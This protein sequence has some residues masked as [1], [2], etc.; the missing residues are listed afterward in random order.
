MNVRHAHCK[1]NTEEDILLKFKMKSLQHT[2][3]DH[4]TIHR[5]EKYTRGPQAKPSLDRQSE[6]SHQSKHECSTPCSD[7]LGG[8][9]GPRGFQGVS[10]NIGPQGVQGSQG[11][12]GIGIAGAQGPQGFQGFRGSIGIQGSQ[13]SSGMQGFQGSIGSGAQGS[14]GF[15]GFQGKVGATGSQGFQGSGTTGSQGFQGSQGTNGSQGNVG[16]QGFQGSQGNIGINGSQGNVGAQGFQGN[17]GAQGFQGGFSSTIGYVYNLNAQTIQSTTVIPAQNQA[18]TFDSTGVLSKITFDGVST[19]ILPST[20]NYSALY[21]VLGQSSVQINTLSFRLGTT[22]TNSSTISII[23]GSQSLTYG[24]NTGQ[25]LL[26]G[27]AAWSGTAGDKIELFNNTNSIVTLNNQTNPPVPIVANH[28]VAQLVNTQT[29][30]STPITVLAGSSIY[31][32]IQISNSSTL[33]TVFTVTD[34]QSHSYSK[35]NSTT[36]GSFQNIEIWYFDGVTASFSYTVTA[37]VSNAGSQ[38]GIQ[39]VEIRGASSPSLAATG[40]AH[41]ATANTLVSVNLTTV[42][43]NNL[44]FMA[45]ISPN[46]TN[47]SAIASNGSILIDETTSSSSIAVYGA[48]FQQNLGVAN[49]YTMTATLVDADMWAAAMVGISPVAN[50]ISQ[51]M[52]ASL[53]IRLD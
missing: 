25:V 26:T 21:T 17:T 40:S 38:I 5:S 35:A 49:T 37:N 4:K 45:L 13:G 27:Q 32:A 30:T 34:N 43:N 31:V 28:S 2:F 24:S 42:I 15:Q 41:A 39:V 22:P 19:L 16:A 23:P 10:G 29:I 9:Q 7:C 51:S 14:M 6:Y 11:S 18:V 1:P 50:A 36:N 44:G 33:T 53:L 52:N 20:G 12:A 46:N 8:S 3:D 48:N 47:Q